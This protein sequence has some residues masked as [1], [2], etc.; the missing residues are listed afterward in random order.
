MKDRETLAQR[1]KENLRSEMESFSTQGWGEGSAMGGFGAVQW[2]AGVRPQRWARRAVRCQL[3]VGG[4]SAGISDGNLPDL[5]ANPSRP[6][7]LSLSKG[8]S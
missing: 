6:F 8:R 3:K 2:Q 7:A 4:G 1:Q 5:R